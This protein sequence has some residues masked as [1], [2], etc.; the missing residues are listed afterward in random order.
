MS[1]YL[2]VSFAVSDPERF[3]GYREAVPALI[4]KY[5]GRYLVRGGDV[6][7]LE[8]SFDGR[9][10]V[11]LEFPSMEAIHEFWNSSDYAE[12]KKLRK[13]AAEFDVLAV[14]GV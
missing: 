13:G 2:I 10:R 5:G 8:G 6:A 11:V 14:P 7:A 9:K 12:V 3:A 4:A 1:A